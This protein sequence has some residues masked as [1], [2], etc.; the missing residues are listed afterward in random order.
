MSREHE[1]LQFIELLLG[2]NV[3]SFGE[4]VTK[5]GR[6]SPFSSIPVR[7]T[8]AESSRTWLIFMQIGYSRLLGAKSLTCLGRHTKVFRFA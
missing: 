1:N 8:L 3:L 7:L 5:S 4:F 2:A 6:L